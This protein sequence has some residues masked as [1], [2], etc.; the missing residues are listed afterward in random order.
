LN[1]FVCA[2]QNSTDFLDRAITFVAGDDSLT[3]LAIPNKHCTQTYYSRLADQ[4]RD[5]RLRYG[6]VSKV[7]ISSIPSQCDYLSCHLMPCMR[8]GSPSYCLTPNYFKAIPKLMTSKSS[9]IK[10]SGA[11]GM[12]AIIIAMRSLMKANPLG[13]AY[14][15][16][17]L[18]NKLFRDINEIVPKDDEEL[19]R[20]NK[21]GWLFNCENIQVDHDQAME[22]LFQRY[23]ASM[24]PLLEE[25]RQTPED[26]DLDRIMFSVPKEW[27]DRDVDTLVE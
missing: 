15:D 9:V 20:F 10:R 5:H 8:D 6:F 12:K 17:C 24:N 27:F 14:C 23:G 1:G 22:F 13:V 11:S 7:F 25:I 19:E 16:M 26:A 3:L 2:E 18:N 21:R 4:V